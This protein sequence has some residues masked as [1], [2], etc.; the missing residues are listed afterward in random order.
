METEEF[1]DDEFHFC[2]ASTV[3]FQGSSQP[4]AISNQPGRNG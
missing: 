4:S 3:C 1:E 2:N